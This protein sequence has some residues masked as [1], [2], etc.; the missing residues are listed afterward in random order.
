[1]KNL[2][3]RGIY[4]FAEYLYAELLVLVLR[5]FGIR[6]ITITCPKV[7]SLK[8][9]IIYPS[10]KSDLVPNPTTVQDQNQA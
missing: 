5:V 8:L 1:M 2:Q 6:L 7:T 4:V 9:E 3:M 10:E